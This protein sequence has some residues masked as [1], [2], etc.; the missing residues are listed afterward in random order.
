MAA[1]D[2]SGVDRRTFFRHSAVLGA[3]A[4]AAGCVHGGTSASAT[5]PPGNGP[6][7]P[8]AAPVPAFELDELT[9]A[10]LQLRQQ[11]DEDSA[12]SLVHKYLGRIDALDRRG[13]ALH[14]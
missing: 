4:G 2:A 10:E 13:P 7:A 11:R 1:D 8:A 14:H 9:L 12:V 5:S 3:A 6:D